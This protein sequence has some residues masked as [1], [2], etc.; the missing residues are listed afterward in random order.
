MKA[1]RKAMRQRRAT[2]P[3]HVVAAHSARI[4]HS[5]WQLPAMAR[6][7]RIAAYLAIAGEVDCMAF[8][9]A[10]LARGREVYVPQLHGQRLLFAPWHPGTALVDNRFGIAEP[11]VPHDECLHGAQLDVVL[12]P[13]VAF[14][15]HGRR[16]GMGGGFYDRSFAFMR[17]RPRWHHPLPIGMAH[18]FQRVDLLPA[19]PWDVGLHAVVTEHAVR[20]F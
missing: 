12:M 9:Q 1:L 16:L 14:D 11:A 15:P 8:M 7:R 5:L 17:Q 18:E 3:R 19:Q 6:S 2:L 10:A 20:L 4:A 13:L